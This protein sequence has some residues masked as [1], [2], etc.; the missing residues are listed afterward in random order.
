M[1]DR[2]KYLFSYKNLHTIIFDF[3]GVFTNN[4]V[5]IDQEGRESV[6]CDRGDGLAIDLL[7]NFSKKNYWNI[8]FFILTTEKNKVVLS[9]AKKLKLQCYCGI[10][11][12]W[13]TSIG[14]L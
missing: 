12:L 10:N 9:R 6:Q 1:T 13:H 11:K 2:T 4:K 7:R 14:K 5:L 3:D 8:D